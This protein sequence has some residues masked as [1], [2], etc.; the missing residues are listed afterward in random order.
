MGKEQRKVKIL[1]VQT[2]NM[3]LGDTIL[4]DNDYYLIKKAMF[5]RKCDILR[6]SISSRDVGQVKY[7][8]AVVFAG[9][10]LKVTNESFWLYFPELIH[11]AQE[12]NVP[13]F[14]SAIGVE[15]YNPEDERS[16]ALKEALNLPCVKGISVR[17]D[18][19]TL[20]RD[21]IT[22]PDIRITPVYDPAVWC[23]KTY[24]EELKRYRLTRNVEGTAKTVGKMIIGLGVVREKLFADY[25]NPQIDRQFQLDFWKK[26]ARELDERDIDWRIFTNGDT[27]DELFAKEVLQYIG[28]GE[29]LP[30]PRDGVNV[31]C[32]ISEFSGVIAG[33]MHSNIVA[34]SLGIPSIGFI[35]NRKLRFWGEK[36]GFPERFLECSEIDGA[37]A[38]NRL[39]T[40]MSEKTGPK[41]SQKRPVYKALKQFARK[42]CVRRDAIS[43]K[44]DYKK[45]LTAIALGGIDIRYKNTNSPEAFEYSLKHGYRNFQ[46]DVRLSADNE[47]MCVNR[48]HKDTFKLLNHP[49]KDAEN[50]YPLESDEFL[51]CRYYNRFSTMSFD[52][53]AK[54]FSEASAD[55]KLKLIIAIG[56]PKEEEQERIFNLLEEGLKKYEIKLEN[57]Y[58]RLE[59]KR[60]VDYA[61]QRKSGY[62]I[63]YH[64]VNPNKSP[65]ETAECIKNALKYCKSRKIKLI[66][67][68]HDLYTD[69]VV[70]LCKEAKIKFCS[71]TGVQ[72]TKIIRGIKNG[73][74]FVGSHYYDVEYLNRL[75]M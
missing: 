20:R 68:H 10:I 16:I 36:I 17:D 12:Y 26:V 25:G 74:E 6:Y 64:M 13:V 62:K 33:R 46:L 72:T 42:W 38:V 45:N 32:D 44:I 56:R 30:A 29:K 70:G 9:G 15:A 35:W 58:I 19:E 66:S 41:L 1:M 67:M 52:T 61:G 31:V 18:I 34:Y 24:S 11:A 22:N 48:W 47:L 49:L 7:V 3:N 60:D 54:S 75:T 55:K 28:H 27:Y 39:L 57:V 71:F 63:I 40:A 69:E 73:A 4:A 43:E 53:F 14:L 65:E 21:Y 5:P 2:A 23:K 8:D 51:Q 37:E 50:V 59:Q